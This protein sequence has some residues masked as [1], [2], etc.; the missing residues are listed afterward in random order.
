MCQLAIKCVH[1]LEKLEKVKKIFEIKISS[2]MPIMD[3]I[4]SIPSKLHLLKSKWFT[5]SFLLIRCQVNDSVSQGT[6]RKFELEQVNAIHVSDTAGNLLL[7]KVFC[8]PKKCTLGALQSC[9]HCDIVEQ[10]TYSGRSAK[11]P[12]V[13]ALWRCELLDQEL[14]HSSVLKEDRVSLAMQL[15]FWTM[16]CC[17][18]PGE[19]CACQLPPFLA[20]QFWWCWRSRVMKRRRWR[21]KDRL[22]TTNKSFCPNCCYVSQC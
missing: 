17:D 5:S 14:N 13:R 3:Q 8:I 18:Y 7:K 9:E 2:F 4:L 10:L 6:T 1:I 20:S 12:G 16:F 15:G 11:P 21:L 19:A 22:L